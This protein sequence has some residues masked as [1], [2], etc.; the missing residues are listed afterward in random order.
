M[1]IAFLPTSGI[2]KTGQFY[3]IFLDRSIQSILCMLFL[4]KTEYQVKVEDTNYV[5]ICQPVN[6]LNKMSRYA[7]ANAAKYNYYKCLFIGVNI[8][9]I[10]LKKRLGRKAACPI[11]KYKK[12]CTDL[13]KCFGSINN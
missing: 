11:R 8:V 9:V 4:K 5:L 13:R 12:I 2:Q 10:A 1:L 6:P 7:P 3:Q